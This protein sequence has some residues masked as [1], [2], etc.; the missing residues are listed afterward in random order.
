MLVSFY[1]K[2]RTFYFIITLHQTQSTN[3]TNIT[4]KL[5]HSTLLLRLY[6][7]LSQRM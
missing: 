1:G 6:T 5:E 7:R 4:E 2:T 3:V